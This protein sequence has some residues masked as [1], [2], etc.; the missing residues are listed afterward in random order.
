MRGSL[1][2]KLNKQMSLSTM[3]CLADVTSSEVQNKN[4]QEGYLFGFTADSW[5]EQFPQIDPKYIFCTSPGLLPSE[6]YYYDPEHYICFPLHIINGQIIMPSSTPYEDFITKEIDTRLEQYRNKEYVRLL[7]AIL[8][9]QSGNIA[10]GIIRSMLEHEPPCPELYQ[11]AIDVY[12]FCDCGMQALGEDAL[13]R[14]IQC[15]SDKQKA[16]TLELL[17]PLPDKVT[18]YRGEGSESTPYRKACSWTLS[19]DTALFFAG[20]KSE[21]ACVLHTGEVNKEDII[22]YIDDRNE[23]EIIVPAGKVHIVKSQPLVD[24]KTFVSFVAGSSFTKTYAFP[25]S[26][27]TRNIIQRT[28]SL[29]EDIHVD[30]HDESHPIRVALLASYLYRALV[31]L[32]LY[33]ERRRSAYSKALPLYEQLISAAIYHDSGRW[34][35][36]PNDMHG[37]AGYEKF[38]QDNGDDEIV[39]FLTTFHCKSSDEARAYW[40]EHFAGQEDVWLAFQIMKDADALDRVRFGKGCNDYTKTAF[41]HLEL[42]KRMIPAA[43]QLA[44][45][46]LY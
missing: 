16:T 24:V 28:R 1:Y 38:Q 5:K 31:L 37:A 17:S 14:L 6:L 4:A 8:S 21:S 46:R 10:L 41:L 33:T 11:A 27:F 22:E 23:R 40:T 12:S 45:A 39:E 36:E 35:N 44:S 2:S 3:R 19:M 18:V 29:Y 20:W 32:P 9:E 25:E 30:D 7:S 34:D 15:K 43:M 42:S 13:A 26:T